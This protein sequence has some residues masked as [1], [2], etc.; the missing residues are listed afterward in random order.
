MPGG[1]GAYLA[2]ASLAL[3]LGLGL[4]LRELS[5]RG[6]REPLWARLRDDGGAARVAVLLAIVALGA[7]LSGLLGGPILAAPLAVGLALS[8]LSGLRVWGVRAASA[9]ITTLLLACLALGAWLGP[10]IEPVAGRP[11]IAQGGLS[12]AVPHWKA[13][14]RVARDFPVLGAGLGSYPALV[15]FYKSTDE[16][17]NTAHSALARW[18]AESGL[19]GLGL[20]TLGAGWCLWRLPG[21]LRRV[22][23]ADWVLPASLAGAMAAFALFSAIHWSVELSAVSLSACAVAGTANR[24]LA[25]GTDLFVERA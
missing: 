9:A 4:A 22:E 20:L 21:A 10:G 1:P 25:G 16:T 3:P 8:G 2:L 6:S 19:A 24:W 12:A 15:P 5:P 23:R 14:A 13:A 7:G 18:A 17:P 11:P